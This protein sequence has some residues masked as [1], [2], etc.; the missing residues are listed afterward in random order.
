MKVSRKTIIRKGKSPQQDL[1]LQP[2]PYKEF[3]LTIEL[4]GD[5]DSQLII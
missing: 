1:N 3:A 4:W 2:N 5:F